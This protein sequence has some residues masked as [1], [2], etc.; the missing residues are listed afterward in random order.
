MEEV[1]ERLQVETRLIGWT[2]RQV[3]VDPLG[4]L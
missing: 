3:T 1:T 2:F 4:L